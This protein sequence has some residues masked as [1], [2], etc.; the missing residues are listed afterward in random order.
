MDISNVVF[1][2][3]SLS[4]DPHK[5][6]TMPMLAYTGNRLDNTRIRW[7]YTKFRLEYTRFFWEYPRFTWDGRNSFGNLSVWQVKHRKC[8]FLDIM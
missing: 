4:P 7:E 2:Q 3:I 8:L 1:F 5:V 6:P